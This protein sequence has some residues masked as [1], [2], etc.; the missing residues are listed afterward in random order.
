MNNLCSVN[1]LNY[2][3]LVCK[4]TS[5]TSEEVA[6]TCNNDSKECGYDC[7]CLN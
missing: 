4:E 7:S 3:T 6:A 2:S 5:E 1:S